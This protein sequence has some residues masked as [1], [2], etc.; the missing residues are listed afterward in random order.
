[1]VFAGQ[2]HF[3]SPNQKYQSTEGKVLLNSEGANDKNGD[4]EHNIYTWNK[5]RTKTTNVSSVQANRKTQRTKRASCVKHLGTN[6]RGGSWTEYH[7]SS[8]Q[9]NW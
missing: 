8:L 9:L 2:M 7:T 6:K 5:C 1:M 3:L 4:S